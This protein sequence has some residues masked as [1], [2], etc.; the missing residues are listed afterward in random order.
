MG[1]R[2]LNIFEYYEQKDTLP[3]ENNHTRNLAIVL[4][5]SDLLRDK[6]LWK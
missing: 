2:H 4:I 6:F 3:I 5:S 1:N